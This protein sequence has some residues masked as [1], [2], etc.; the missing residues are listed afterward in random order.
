MTLDL[1]LATD[2]LEHPAW[3]YFVRAMR[4]RAHGAEETLDAWT[5]FRAGWDRGVRAGTNRF[6]SPADLFPAP[7]HHHFQDGVCRC[8]M[9]SP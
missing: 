7:H 8:G 4:G 5:W 3:P 6:A 2:V 9:T 1:I